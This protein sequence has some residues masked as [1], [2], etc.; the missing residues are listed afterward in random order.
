MYSKAVDSYNQYNVNIESPEK[1][2][3]MLYEGALKFVSFAK[4]SI[5]KEDVEKKV[6]W[7]NR[8]MDIFT[9]LITSLNFEKGGN[10]A[11]YL[12]GLYEHQIRL[13]VSA[14][15]NN[16]TKDLDTIIDVLKGLIDAWKEEIQYEQ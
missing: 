16:S 8:T 10:V 14:N 9:E 15:I 1:L 3:L 12:S 2:I 4:K 11:V 5:E 6:Y 13:L 7:I